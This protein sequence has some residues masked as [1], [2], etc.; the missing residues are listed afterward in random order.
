MT[1][2][3]G[4]D[5]GTSG[6]RTAVLDRDGS[7]VSMA[8]AAHLP[9]PGDEIDANLW[10]TA[11][12]TCLHTQIATL[13]E[14]GLDPHAIQDIAVDGTSGS[15]VLTDAQLRPVSPALMYNSKGFDAEARAIGQIAPSSHITR[16]SNSALAR[17]MRLVS[18]AQASPAHLLHQADFIVAK[19]MGRGGHSDHNNALKTGF[20]PES[21]RWPDWIGDLITPDWLPQVHP[22]GTR[23]DCLDPAVAQAL[24]L[25]TRTR[26]HAGTTD[27]IAAFL[28]CAP[29]EEGMAVTSLGSTLAIKILSPKRID[30]PRIGLY[31]H[32]IG[33]V[34][35]VGGAS[36]TGGAVL[37]SVLPTQKVS[38]LSARI[39]PEQETGLQFYPL[40]QP[41]ERFPINDPD[42]QPIMTPRPDDD[43]LFL[44]A[45]FEGI[46][47][48]E[49][50]CYAEIEMRGGGSPKRIFSAGGGAKD[51]A[52]SRI[53]ARSLGM[54]PVMSQT[55]EAAIG[56]AKL[57][58]WT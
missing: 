22:V 11:V 44:Q 53:R 24:G 34:W 5:I 55:T 50:R 10:W 7:V 36:N 3:L 30:D 54:D 8:R 23:L 25:S 47:R 19:L 13:R 48:I 9:Q 18:K 28:A 45:L 33:Q 32:R 21:Q 51:H 41:G 12:Q 58:R 27:S 39:D 40:L 57:A 46:A 56:A 14:I 16:G 42:L 20:D 15:M 38:E 43:A 4:I 1:L 2:S 6:I 31:S 49:A 29:L 52:F 35:L 26:L 37:A 17:A